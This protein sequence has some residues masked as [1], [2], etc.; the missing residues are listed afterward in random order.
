MLAKMMDRPLLIS[1]LIAHAGKWH[2]DQEIVTKTVEGPIHRYTWADAENR[3]KQLAKALINLG[4]KEG[5][6]IGTLA[7]NTFRH[8]E[9]YYGISGIGAITHTINPRLFPDQLEYVV[10]HA[11][12]QFLVIDTTFIGLVEDLLPKVPNVKGVIVL[13]DK[14]HMPDVSGLRNPICY[15]ELIASEDHDFHWPTFDDNSAAA[16]CYTSGT[17][18]NPKGALYAHKS[19]IIHALAQIAPDCMGLSSRDTVMPVVPMFHVNAWGTPYAAAA[20]GCKLVLPGRD[21]DGKS[22]YDLITAEKVNF[23]AAV[24]TIWMMLL[25]HIQEINGTLDNLERVVIGGSAC[26]RAMMETFQNKYGVQVLHAWGMTEMSPLGTLNTPKMKHH[27]LSEVEKMDLQQSAGRVLFGV[28]MKI[29]DEDGKTLP[30]DG[31][32]TGELKVTGPWIISDY[33]N[34][35]EK[36]GAHAEEG[37]FSTGDVCAIDPDGYIWITDRLKDVIKSGG[38]WISSID[39]ENIAVGHPKVAEAAAIGMP[40]PKWDERPLLVVVRTQ[41]GQDLN[42]NEMLSFLEGKIAKWWT[43]DDIVFVDELP[44]TA[45]GKL[46]K[47]Q[48]RE[49]FK[50]YILPTAVEGGQS[51]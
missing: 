7:W 16:L 47:L 31:K 35:D 36:A 46:S 3:A 9:A 11:D 10:N 43:P 27:S 6:R 17:T 42:K 44:H 23:T 24:P 1:S 30:N 32:A 4:I 28:D 18:G 29:V 41:A 34:L 26:P 20:T 21:L 48:L 22:I 8:L 39:L 12:D 40:H 37:W 5:D 51:N 49:R 14:E 25:A 13:T 19:T 45:T 38:E 50:D 33:F 15:E 2:S